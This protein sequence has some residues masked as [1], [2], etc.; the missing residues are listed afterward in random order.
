MILPHDIVF[1]SGHFPSSIPYAQ[2]TRTTFEAYAARHG[3][4]HYYDEEVPL[5]KEM[6]SLHYQR[7][8]SLEKALVRFPNVQWLV[9][10]DSDVYV[11]ME[12]AHVKLEEVLDLTDTNILYHFFHERPW[13]CPVNTGVKI[14]NAKALSLEKW[15]HSMKDTSPWNE[16]PYEQKFM[17][18]CILPTFSQQCVI[19]DP[20]VLN[21][22]IYL[23]PSKVKEALF[24]HMCTM[25]GEER[26]KRMGALS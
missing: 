2:K 24:I 3:Y 15:A 8:V 1:V 20:Y 18:E 7:C 13:E 23:Y 25:S 5:C 21:C 12:Q 10:T 6:H 14:V 26:N 16:F 9:W 22:I 4:H 19:H 11:N 17:A